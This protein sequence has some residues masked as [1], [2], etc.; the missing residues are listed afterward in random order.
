MDGVSLPDVVLTKHEIF[1]YMASDLLNSSLDQVKYFCL[2]FQK[3]RTDLWSMKRRLCQTWLCTWTLSN[4]VCST[5]NEYASTNCILAQ[6]STAQRKST[7]ISTKP[8]CQGSAIATCVSHSACM[9]CRVF[10]FSDC[11]LFYLQGHPTLQF[12]AWLDIEKLFQLGR[13]WAH[14][15]AVKKVFRMANRHGVIINIIL[16]AI[17][18]VLSAKYCTPLHWRPNIRRSLLLWWISITLKST[19]FDIPS[20]QL[21]L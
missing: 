20:W 11:K 6:Q 4:N 15:E 16:I 17:R 19:S 18:A 1:S 8:D 21:S 7:S 10:W 12:P 5:A 9:K 14:L 3:K 2:S 13:W